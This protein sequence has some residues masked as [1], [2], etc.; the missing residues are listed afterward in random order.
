MRQA[1]RPTDRV[2][3]LAARPVAATIIRDV[4][5]STTPPPPSSTSSP[6]RAAAPLQ[7]DLAELR[8][9]V[10]TGS[11]YTGSLHSSE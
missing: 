3:K 5:R 9:Q 1:G 8:G 2:D 7:A 4:R 11:G 6:G 10:A